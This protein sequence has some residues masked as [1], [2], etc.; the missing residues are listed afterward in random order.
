MLHFEYF[1]L[2]RMNI[3]QHNFNNVNNFVFFFIQLYK[4]TTTCRLIH[5]FL[6]NSI[7]ALNLSFLIFWQSFTI[8]I[9]LKLMLNEKEEKKSFKL[10]CVVFIEQ[11]SCSSCSCTLNSDSNNERIK[12]TRVSETIKILIAKHKTLLLAR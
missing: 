3:F 10:H 2:L 7:F 11:S 9:A 12:A 1:F 8:N 4:N 6:W 5:V